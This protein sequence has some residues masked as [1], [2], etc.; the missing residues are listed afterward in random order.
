MHVDHN[1]HVIGCNMHVTCTLFRIGQTPLDGPLHGWPPMAAGLHPP[2]KNPG[3]G[4]E[5]RCMYQ[6][7]VGG[8]SQTH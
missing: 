5:Y 1:M 7:K 3:Y 2:L 6:Y 8:D 4:P